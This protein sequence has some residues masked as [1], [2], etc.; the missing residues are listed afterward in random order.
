MARNAVQAASKQME[1][2]VRAECNAELSSTRHDADAAV[3]SV[4][5]QSATAERTARDADER[6]ARSEKQ[7]REFRRES[8]KLRFVSAS[9]IHVLEASAEAAAAQEN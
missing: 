7:L 3:M 6:A 5:R 1:Q 8:G 9:R 4:R 2:R